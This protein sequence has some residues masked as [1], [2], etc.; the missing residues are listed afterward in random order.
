MFV[1]PNW[2]SRVLT[3]RSWTRHSIR[4]CSHAQ[5]SPCGWRMSYLSSPTSNSATSLT[6]HRDT[7]RFG[8]TTFSTEDA[9]QRMGGPGI[10]WGRAVGVKKCVFS[11]ILKWN[12]VSSANPCPRL[13]ES[14]S[15]PSRTYP[16]TDTYATTALS[17][18]LGEVVW[19]H[20]QATVLVKGPFFNVYLLRISRLP[21]QQPTG[22]LVLMQNR[23]WGRSFSPVSFLEDESRASLPSG[24]RASA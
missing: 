12:G 7:R 14:S 6:V 8:S 18:G 22:W 11:F 17:R 2:S 24:Q 1:P 23:Q 4:I 21:S 19:R 5:R 10:G 16:L 9:I 20:G 13:Q 15:P 3:L